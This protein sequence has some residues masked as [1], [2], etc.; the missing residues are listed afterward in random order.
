MPQYEVEPDGSPATFVRARSE[1]D[2]VA[3][4]LEGAD[5]P[6]LESADPPVLEGAEPGSGWR[7]VVVGGEMWGRVRPRDR[8]RFRRD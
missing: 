4:V 3:R 6:V 7:V 8:M 2:A 1:A 5:P